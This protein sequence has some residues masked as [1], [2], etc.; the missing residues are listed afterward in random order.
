MFTHKHTYIIS[1]SL[2]PSFN[3][4]IHIR[5]KGIK[6]GTFWIIP[7]PHFVLKWV[8]AVQW[9]RMKIHLKHFLSLLLSVFVFLSCCHLSSP[10]FDTLSTLAT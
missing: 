6:E 2:L 3:L 4:Y 1:R 7:N 9:Y 10:R 8:I 5:E